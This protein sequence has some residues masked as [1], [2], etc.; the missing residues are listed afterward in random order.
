MF[1]KYAVTHSWLVSFL[2]LTS[3]LFLSKLKQ[4]NVLTGYSAPS[5][6]ISMVGSRGPRPGT[7]AYELAYNAAKLF[8]A[9]GFKVLS[10]G[11]AG[12]MEA[13]CHGA[14]DGGGETVGVLAPS[15]V[16]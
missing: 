15:A 10:G 11:Y 14:K 5:R 1:I 12:V 4:Y 3:N 8:A 9:K 7:P 13:V 2:S 6:S 16:C